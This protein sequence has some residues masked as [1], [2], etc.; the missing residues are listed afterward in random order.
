MAIEQNKIKVLFAIGNLNVGGAEKLVLNQIKNLDRDKFAPVLCTLFPADKNNYL[1]E[2]GELKD[3][4]YQQFFFRGPW[5]AVSWLKV[6]LFL[7]RE[8]FDV[9]CCHLFEANFIIRLL[10]LFVGV[11]TVFIFEHNI[12]WKKP[13]WKIIADRALAKKTAKIFVDSQAILDFTAKQEKISP[14]R[15]AILPYPIELAEEL[16]LNKEKIKAGLGL[17]ADSLVIGSVARFVE[18]KGQIY[19][20][21]AAEKILKQTNAKIYFLLV[22]YGHKEA[23]LKKLIAD[24]GL[25]SR[26]ILSPAKDIKE[27]LPILDIYVISSLWEGQPIAMLEAMAAGLP[28]VA[29]RVGGIP[30]IM[31][32]GENGLLAEAKDENSLAEKI[33]KLAENQELRLRL[34]Q[35]AKRTAENFSLPIYIRKLE[36]YFIDGYG[37]TR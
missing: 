12:Y 36:K 37:P 7:R 17:P 10:N 3:V 21:R 32:D 15:F 6:F 19:L 23:E 9:L 20:I 24:L 31:F 27:V 5:D 26:V 30:E 34:G 14:D 1:S 25:E 29:T 16:E 4:K 2:A 35:A 13:G 11:K 22:G 8:N 28:V 18:Q 33:L